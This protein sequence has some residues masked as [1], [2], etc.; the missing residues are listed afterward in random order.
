[1]HLEDPKFGINETLLSKEGYDGHFT[2]AKAKLGY[3]G[4][5]VFIKRRGGKAVSKDGK[6]KKKQATLGAFRKE[7][8]KVEISNPSNASNINPKEQQFLEDLIPSDISFAIGKKEHDEEGRF[9]SIDYPLFTLVN[10]Y[11]PNSGDKLVRLDYRIKQWDT[12]FL[13]YM[14]RKQEERKLPVIWIGDLN[15]A[16]TAMDVWNDG[17][18]HLS[19]TAG[20]TPEERMSFQTQL[21]AGFVDAFRCLHPKAWGHYTYWSQR[22]RNRPENQGLRLDYFICSRSLMDEND[23]KDGMKVDKSSERV[24]VRDSYMIPDQVGSDHCPI[25]LELEIKKK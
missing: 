12:D 9:I 25:M 8:P 4:T 17:A 24:V 15:V 21:D 3:S 11:V 16:H 2:C 5:A 1:M 13:Q 18:K 7:V 22:A 23:L 19:K 20:T 6:K 14:Q 10:V